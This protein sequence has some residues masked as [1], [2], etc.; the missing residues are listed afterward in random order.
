MK[1]SDPVCGTVLRPAEGIASVVYEGKLY[2]FCSQE[3]HGRFW[4]NPDLYLARQDVDTD[5]ELTAAS[6]RRSTPLPWHL[7]E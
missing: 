1:T 3:C 5:S 2:H 6:V 7:T 4:A